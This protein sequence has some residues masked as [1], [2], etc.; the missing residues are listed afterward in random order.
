M[1][2]AARPRSRHQPPLF[3]TI[4]NSQVTLRQPQLVLGPAEVALLV[5]FLQALLAEDPGVGNI[6]V[7]RGQP[8]IELELEFFVEVA[9][10][11]T[12]VRVRHQ[13]LQDVG[14]LEQLGC[15]PHDGV[16][17]AHAEPVEDQ[18]PAGLG[19]LSFKSVFFIVIINVLVLPLYKI[20]G[21]SP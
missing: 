15:R 1:A 21:L 3:P 19:F 12:I 6:K 10:G 16:V 14:T 7:V 17:V 4:V 20:F 9:I 5:V 13:P 18:L 2:E 11:P 8:P